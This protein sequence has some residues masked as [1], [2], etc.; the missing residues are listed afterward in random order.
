MT[1][2]NKV[3]DTSTFTRLSINHCIQQ[4]LKRYAFSNKEKD[5]L[6]W[7]HQLD[8]DFYGPELLTVHV[9]FNLIKNAL[10]YTAN[11]EGASINISTKTPAAEACNYVKFKD[12]GAGISPEV[13]PRLFEA[14]FT[15]SATGMGV[16]LSFSKMVMESLGGAIECISEEGAFTEFTLSF[17]KVAKDA[18]I[19]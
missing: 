7:D 11:K 4:A 13:M 12:T 17:P 1:A 2:G 16:G 14:F 3:I 8:F 10:K 5:I 6:H 15:T 9:F 19:S 18:G